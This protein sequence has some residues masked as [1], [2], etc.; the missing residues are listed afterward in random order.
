MLNLCRRGFLAMASGTLGAHAWQKDKLKITSV[1]AAPLRVRETIPA[2][3]ASEPLSDFDPR[4]WRNFG[5]FSQLNGAILVRIR[6]DQGVTGYGMG[7][8]GTAACFIIENHLKTLLTGVNPL[9]VELIWDQLF[10]STSFYGRRGV[11]IQALSGI[12]LALW[13]IAGK[14]ANAPVYR[15]LGGPTRSRVAGYYT[16]NDVERGLKL[17]FAGVKISNFADF[18]QG[19]E[20][21]QSNVQRVMDARKRIGAEP[22]LMLDALC[23]WDVPYTLE[24]AERVAEARLHF[25]EEPLLPD[26][27]DG[28][29]RLCREIRSTRV[30]SG[31][32]E[33]TAYGFQE[34]LRNKAA[35]VL[36]PD[37]TW[38]GGLTECRRVAAASE[39]AGIPVVPHRGGSVYG[40]TLLLTCRTPQLAESLGTGESGNEIM[41]LLTPKLEKGH[42]L[43]PAGPGFGVDFTDSI[44]RK[45]APQLT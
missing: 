2:G 28:Y 10:S 36:Q 37:L 13:D 17:G 22:L 45:Y 16:G 35:H 39:A 44:L 9:N 15:L 12:D 41:E 25:L 24:F 5:P 32:H 21:M 27:I 20:A 11:V 29:A 7:G 4:R 34:L 19:R 1:T 31:E 3:S 42:Y 33:A 14:H 6:T 43:P 40:M 30:A 8:G 23:A 38:S 26:D 18:R